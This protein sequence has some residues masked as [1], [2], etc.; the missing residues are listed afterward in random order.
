GEIGEWG[1][2]GEK[3]CKFFLISL[4]SLI[5]LIP[6]IPLIFLFP[7]REGLGVGYYLIPCLLVILKTPHCRLCQGF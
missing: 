3:N 4:I 7:S 5:S 2:W 6:L 1:E